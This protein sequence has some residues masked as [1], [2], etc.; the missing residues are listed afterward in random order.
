MF[1]GLNGMFTTNEHVLVV[2]TVW[3]P[4]RCVFIYHTEIFFFL[5]MLLITNF[6]WVVFQVDLGTDAKHCFC[7]SGDLLAVVE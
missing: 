6:F 4:V 1:F 3:T 5:L 2:V 7:K